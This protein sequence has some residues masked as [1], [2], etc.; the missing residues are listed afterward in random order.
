MIEKKGYSLGY[1]GL[2]DENY[3]GLLPR[4][5]LN[6]LGQYGAKA[7]DTYIDMSGCYPLTRCYF[8]F[9]EDDGLYYC[10]QHLSGST[11]GSYKDAATGEQ[12][13]FKNILYRIRFTRNWARGIWLF[14]V[15]TPPTAGLSPMAGECYG[16]G[17]EDSDYSATRDITR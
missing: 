2:S 8:E 1:R 12:L 9:N 15:M 11:D 6:T 4:R 13:T 3:F 7:K 10:S 14:S 16:I 5:K 17:G